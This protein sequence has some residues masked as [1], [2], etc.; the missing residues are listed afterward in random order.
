MH[1]LLQ[2]SRRVLGQKFPGRPECIA[3][4]LHPIRHARRTQ[5]QKMPEQFV[6][7]SSGLEPVAHEKCFKSFP[8]AQVFKHG[9]VSPRFMSS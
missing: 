4:H 5:K 9:H 6:V 2:N 8:I 1:R 3:M 7:V